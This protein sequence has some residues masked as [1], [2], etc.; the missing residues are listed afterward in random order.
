MTVEKVV[1]FDDVVATHVI[2]NG[3]NATARTVIMLH[4][5]ASSKNEV[6]GMYTRLA[7]ELAK[8]GINSIRIDFRGFG[9]TKV[10][11]T[12]ATVTT[13]IEDAKNTFTYLQKMGVKDISVQGFSLGSE[14]AILAF[15]DNKEIKSMSLWSTPKE[16]MSQYSE[17][18]KKDRDIAYKTGVVDL[19]LGWRKLSLSKAFFE[20]LKQYNVEQVF[21][22]FKGDIYFIAGSID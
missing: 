1:K 13:M 6:G 7:G 17:I 22:K 9:D 16:L 14:I 11:S 18:T 12:K 15:S 3:N 4:G 20:N 5:F 2:A 19:D 10:D 8:K 21:S